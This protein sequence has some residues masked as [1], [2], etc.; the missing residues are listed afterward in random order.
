MSDSLQPHGLLHARLPCPSL[1]PE[2]AQTHVHG[3]SDAIQP[4]HPLLL[5]SPTALNL[6]QH[7]GLFR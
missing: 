7:Q 5:P 6:S 1:S 4:S 3:V 2:L